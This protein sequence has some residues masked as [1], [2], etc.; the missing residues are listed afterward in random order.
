M[1]GIAGQQA[2]VFSYLSP[3]QRMRDAKTAR[4][5]GDWS[6]R[7]IRA[8]EAINRGQEAYRVDSLRRE[9]TEQD[10]Y[11]QGIHFEGAWAQKWAQFENWRIF[12]CS[13]LL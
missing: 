4:A 5:N 1:R 9:T 2:D 11:G 3:E 6:R 13:L 7:G 8:N 12:G 10:C